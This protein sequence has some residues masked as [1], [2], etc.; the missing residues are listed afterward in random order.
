MGSRGPRLRVIPCTFKAAC[1]FIANHHRHH[2]P[3]AGS[4]INVA[5]I[6]DGGL[7]RGVAT[8]G[9]PVARMLDDGFTLEVNRVATDGAPNACSALYGAIARIARAM[10]YA[11][12]VTYT[13]PSEGG[14]SLRGAGW[15]VE[16]E[17]GGGAWVHSGSA[18]SNDWPLSTKWRWRKPL[19][20]DAVDVVWPTP[21]PLNGQVD[22]FLSVEDS[23][24]RVK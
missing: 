3:P 19:Q 14:S 9:R 21:S 16:G 12:I 11:S 20:V 7:V 18:R 2:R 24:G 23:C 17:S 5:V 1:S 6:D 8:A 10:G 4:V 22:M 15:D 13:L